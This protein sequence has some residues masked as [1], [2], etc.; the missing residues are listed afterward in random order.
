MYNAVP[1]KV[2]MSIVSL[3]PDEFF[4]PTN[5]ELNSDGTLN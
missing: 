2:A 1:K 4:F 5:K 3:V